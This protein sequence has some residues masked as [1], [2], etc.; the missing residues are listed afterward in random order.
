M[1]CPCTPSIARTSCRLPVR[2]PAVVFGVGLPRLL[3]PP[4]PRRPFRLLPNLLGTNTRTFL[5]AFSPFF[6]P[7]SQPLHANT[8]T[9]RARSLPLH[10]RHPD[11]KAVDAHCR[12][13]IIPYVILLATVRYSPQPR[14]ASPLLAHRL[15]RS[16]TTRQVVERHRPSSARASA[17]LIELFHLTDYHFFSLCQPVSLFCFSDAISLAVASRFGVVLC[18]AQSQSTPP[19]ISD[20]IPANTRSCLILIHHSYHCLFHDTLDVNVFPLLP[21][22]ASGSHKPRRSALTD[23]QSYTSHGHAV[24]ISNT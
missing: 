1:L 16:Y 12:V 4:A 10:T 7:P 22:A 5:S 18:Q 11:V 23:P 3:L 15:D 17:E 8:N 20:L 19:T 9:F 2:L 21:S 14:S 13:F 24:R 6:I